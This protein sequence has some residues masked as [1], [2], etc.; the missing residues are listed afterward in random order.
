MLPTPAIA[1]SQVNILSD[2]ILY[3]TATSLFTGIAIDRIN[4]STRKF[5]AE[6]EERRKAE[7]QMRSS[8]DRFKALLEATFERETPRTQSV[9]Y[10][11]VFQCIDCRAGDSRG[12]RSIALEAI[13]SEHIAQ[14]NQ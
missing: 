3:I 8:Q 12:G 5:E 13:R 6:I 9:I 10:F 11:R 1:Y 14:E 7:E 2:Y 4:K